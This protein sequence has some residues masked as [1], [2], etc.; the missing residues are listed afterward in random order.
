MVIVQDRRVADVETVFNPDQG[1]P[2]NRL[3]ATAAPL[4]IN[5]PGR[6]RRRHADCRR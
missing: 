6:H 5:G 1:N 4:T 2:V 3:F